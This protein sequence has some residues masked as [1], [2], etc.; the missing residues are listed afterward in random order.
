MGHEFEGG[1][2][3]IGGI[4]YQLGNMLR[5]GLPSGMMPGPEGFQ[6][7]F[8]MAN[9][10]AMP[11]NLEQPDLMPPVLGVSQLQ[12]S[13]AVAQQNTLNAISLQLTTLKNS[14]SYTIEDQDTKPLDDG[15]RAQRLATLCTMSRDELTLR[16]IELEDRL[17]KRDQEALELE[18]AL[19]ATNTS[20]GELREAVSALKQMSGYIVDTQ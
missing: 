8:M 9:G 1:M 20:T 15:S 11:F 3:G 4:D 13:A 7:D 12:H 18:E 14:K 19:E 5:M 2:E 10:A 17:R 16:I 6:M